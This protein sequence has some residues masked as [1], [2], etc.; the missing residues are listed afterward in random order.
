MKRLRWLVASVVIVAAS[1]QLLVLYEVDT[2]A[3]ASAVR[4][5]LPSVLGLASGGGG[6]NPMATS[7]VAD[8]IGSLVKMPLYERLLTVFPYDKEHTIERNIMQTA[9]VA[10]FTNREVDI[11]RSN[12][13]IGFNYTMY[14]DETALELLLRE[15]AL[16]FPEIIEAYNSFPRVILRV[17]FFRYASVFLRGGVYSD[18]DTLLVK[19]ID[20]WISYNETVLGVPNNVRAVVGIESECDCQD[21]QNV[22]SRRVQFCQ[23]TLQASKHHPLYARL[24]ANIVEM[25][26]TNYDADNR[27]LTIGEKKYEFSAGQQSYYD[28]IMQLTGP[29]A[30]TTAV[31]DYLNSLQDVTQINPND[32]DAIFA[33]LRH[34]DPDVK[35]HSNREDQWKKFGWENVTKIQEP[36][37]VDDVLILPEKYFNG[38][39]E[40]AS[41]LIEHGFHGSWKSSLSGV[42]G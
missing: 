13:E 27:T 7:V 39:K 11:W 17:D 36:V 19:P 31:F 23:W 3:V 21:W 29:G 16:V 25:M 34:P 28:G 30:Y 20:D 32:Q 42:T 40:D 9:K 5:N 8:D 10:D 1:V 15:F 35:L 14:D 4:S 33:S 41:C 22:Y 6:K 18:T 12:A 26:T 24:L 38:K 2:E 37:L